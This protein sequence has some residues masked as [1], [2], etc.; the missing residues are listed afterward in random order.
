M[1][2][3][4][5]KLLKKINAIVQVDIKKKIEYFILEKIYKFI[6]LKF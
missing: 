2:S 5:L 3:I 1:Q 4:S 6:I